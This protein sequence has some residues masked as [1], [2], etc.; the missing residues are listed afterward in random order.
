MNKAVMI[1]VLFCLTSLTGCIGDDSTN[2][3]ELKEEDQQIEPVG[4]ND[5]SNISKELDA[6]EVEV[7][8]FLEDFNQLKASQTEMQASDD[9]MS[10]M[11]DQLE[12]RINMLETDMQNLNI[13]RLEEKDDELQS[14]I[15][16]TTQKVSAL[17]SQLSSFQQELTALRDSFNDL[18]IMSLMDENERAVF[19]KMK[20]LHDLRENGAVNRDLTEA[21]LSGSDLS[22]ISFVGADLSHANLDGA[23]FV[24][25]NFTG[26]NMDNS[27]ANGAY[28]RG[29]NFEAASVVGAYWNAV[30]IIDSNMADAKFAETEMHNCIILESDLSNSNFERVNANDCYFFHVNGDSSIWKGASLDHSEFELSSF[31]DADFSRHGESTSSRLVGITYASVSFVGAT[32]AY[33][34]MSHSTM[35]ISPL[36]IASDSPVMQ[37]RGVY[38]M[39]CKTTTSDGWCTEYHEGLDVEFKDESELNDGEMI[40]IY[41]HARVLNC[42][43]FMNADLNNTKLDNSV[44]CITPIPEMTGGS[45][46]TD[47]TVSLQN[48]P[49]NARFEN[50]Q[51]RRAD[52]TNVHFGG[53][54]EGVYIVEGNDWYSNATSGCHAMVSCM[55]FKNTAFS[56]ADLSDS[57]FD[58][59]DLSDSDFAGSS[60]G[61][62]VWGHALWM[63]STWTDSS[64]ISGRGDPNNW[65]SDD[66]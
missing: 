38:A 47:V 17:E 43:D 26:A 50:A 20:L 21:D 15:E 2:L 55:N 23:R 27:H 65:D 56:L 44:I 66:N 61:R 28:F 13:I 22:G 33:A 48:N 59:V 11:M 57:Y 40:R 31:N 54:P 6:L 35:E 29:A 63:D 46:N 5:L 9:T 7:N 37:A 19:H 16:S 12:A 45:A 64:T 25:N 49:I 41:D 3:E 32:F 52:L 58:Y 14:S 4:E 34:D 62:V 51:F 18:T 60:V 39:M 8:K 36:A 10:A 30:E 42:V 53:S 24:G 1:A